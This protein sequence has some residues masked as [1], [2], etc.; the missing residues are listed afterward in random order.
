MAI[1][2]EKFI[3]WLGKNS[4]VIG[5]ALILVSLS[6]MVATCAYAGELKVTWTLP[7]QNT[8]G[9]TIPAT[10]DGSLTGT[11]IEWG[12]CNGTTWGGTSGERVVPAPGTTT[13]I[14]N[15]AP[16]TW[17]VRGYA[18]NTYGL[19]SAPSGVA[20]KVIVP[21]TPNPPVLTVEAGAIAYELKIIGNGEVRL[22][23]SVGTVNADTECGAVYVGENF[24]TVPL[25]AVD[26][27]KT[28]KSSVVVAE[29]TAG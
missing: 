27:D 8:D 7:T 12:V 29:C 28:P 2:K 15:V 13:T 14:T 9:G 19:E 25:D 22:G 16:G 20:S 4:I 18:R 24:A 3:E 5:G 1:S 17:C 6:L 21:P 11:R 26:L 23:R 10:G